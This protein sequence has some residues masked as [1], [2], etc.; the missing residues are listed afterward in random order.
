MSE[1]L[2]NF[3]KALNK[4]EKRL[5]LKSLNNTK[6]SNYYKNLILKYGRAEGYAESLDKNIFGELSNSVVSDCK[7]RLKDSLFHFLTSLQ[8]KASIGGKI[9]QMLDVVS[10][11]V[12]RRQAEE[13]TKILLKAE[14]LALKNECYFLLVMIQ[15]KFIAME[16][17]RFYIEDAIDLDYLKKL[18][19]QRNRTIEKYKEE[20][21][22]IDELQI[23]TCEYAIIQGYK[24]PEI[25]KS[26]IPNEFID[27]L[28]PLNKLEAKI[29]RNMI[30]CDDKL[31]Y[32]YV[33]ELINM[34]E[35]DLKVLN[36]YGWL[37]SS[38][39]RYLFLAVF[40]GIKLNKGKETSETLLKYDFVKPKTAF[41]KSRHLNYKT[42]SYCKYAFYIN[43]PCFAI[44]QIKQFESFYVTD[45]S[46]TLNEVDTLFTA[47]T[48]YFANGDFIKCEELVKA[49]SKFDIAAFYQNVIKMIELVMVYE[50]S[51]FCYL[52]SLI[53]QCEN[54]NRKSKSE[55]DH[56][57]FYKYFIKTVKALGQK[58]YNKA[59]AGF[60]LLY[61][62]FAKDLAF[63]K[64]FICWLVSKNIKYNKENYQLFLEKYE[65]EHFVYKVK[66]EK[67]FRKA[68]L[69]V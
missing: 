17:S 31:T 19:K 48:L 15:D 50:S 63:F 33:D 1:F 21:K 66:K 11:L 22:S 4:T 64:Y 43:K 8:S 59:N 13:A 38:Y 54:K 16:E 42:I 34:I 35:K 69:F 65:F 14:K 7:N 28:I 26:F 30:N 62:L 6:R 51:D 46:Y 61:N 37:I 23:S 27:F 10:M 9:K 60:K 32:K 55:K 45:L 39:S 29:N 40:Y 49:L 57:Q 24:I 20:V 67:K 56:V 53:K 68:T 25:S 5:Y 36:R 47:L 41:S 12:E 44:E 18:Q 52:N 2:F 3:V 58:E